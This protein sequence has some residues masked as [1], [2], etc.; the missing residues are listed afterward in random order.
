MNFFLKK[1]TILAE[2][3]EWISMAKTQEASYGGLTS[4]H[5]HAICSLF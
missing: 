1:E 4:G 5:N 3:D 2:V